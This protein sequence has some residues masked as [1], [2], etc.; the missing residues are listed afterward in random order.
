MKKFII[1]ILAIVLSISM[2]G[3]NQQEGNVQ[4]DLKEENIKK[5]EA[6]AEQSSHK[7]VFAKVP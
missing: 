6:V 3:C 2:L 5:E 7:T 1:L 4:E